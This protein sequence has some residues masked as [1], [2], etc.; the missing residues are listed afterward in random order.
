MN[1]EMNCGFTQLLI[2]WEDAEKTKPIQGEEVLLWMKDGEIHAGH[3]LEHANK[4]QRNTRRW[5][6]YK[7]NKCVDEDQVRAWAR[8]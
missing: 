7:I 8:F 4:Y 2:R 6:I 3:W 5:K 1:E